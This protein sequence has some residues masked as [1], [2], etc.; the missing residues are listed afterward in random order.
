MS[1]FREAESACRETN[2]MFR[3]FDQGR[4]QFF[5]WVDSVLHRAQLKIQRVLGKVPSLERLGYRFGPGATTLTKKR[6][7]SAREKLRAGFACSE[8][9]LPIASA[10]L[11]EFPS[12][13]EAHRVP[14]SPIRVEWCDGYY[15]E[16]ITVPI[17]IADGAVNFAQKNATIYRVIVAEPPLN[18]MVQLPVGDHI[19]GCLAAFAVDLKDQT[20]NQNLALEGS[21]TDRLATIDLS[22]ASDTISIECVFHLLPLEWATFL[23]RLRTGHVQ[24]R[25]GRFTLEKFSSMGNGFTFPLESLIFWALTCAVAEEW[26]STDVGGKFISVYGD[27]IICPSGIAAD[28]AEV[29]RVCGFTVNGGKSFVKGPFRESC[30]KDYF[31]G[32]DIRPF[33]QKEL[34]SGR[35]LFVLHN[36]YVR[37]GDPDRAE[38]VLKRIHPALR[39]Y[40][41]DGYGDGHLLGSFAKHRKPR[42]HHNGYAGYIFDTFT[43]CALRDLKPEH[44]GDSVL[45]QYSAYR[46]SAEKLINA[47]SPT[48]ASSVDEGVFWARFARGLSAPVDV[49]PVP[50]NS[51]GS[52]SSALPGNDGYKRMSIYVLG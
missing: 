28:V 26:G 36:H 17:R 12:F 44:I 30:G 19:V 2:L 49:A 41:P 38:M 1:K 37:H 29:L 13:S 4:F 50:F 6:N 39:I 42:Q 46:R 22:S 21:L 3:A 51:D 31:L 48:R 5:P 15:D 10:I 33:Y 23:S 34:V 45:P 8:E 43:Q 32:I 9:L 24:Y 16:W 20:R 18:G 7:A 25:D 40:G 52:K 27:D 47:K 35:S 14:G 11:Q